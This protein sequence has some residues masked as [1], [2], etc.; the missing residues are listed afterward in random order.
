MNI[1]KFIDEL[2]S[3][4]D[5]L[6]ELSGNEDI[7]ELNAN[8]EDVLFMLSESDDETDFE[9]ELQDALEELVDIAN[10]YKAIPDTEKYGDSISAI[11]A[12]ITMVIN[13]R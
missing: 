13:N 8:L 11:V 4:L 9:E 7:E 12:R 3:L 2:N 5:D 1:E 6:D 10:G